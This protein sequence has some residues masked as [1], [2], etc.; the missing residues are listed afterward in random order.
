M[1]A[2]DELQRLEREI[3]AAERQPRQPPGK[4]EQWRPAEKPAQPER[5]RSRS[6]AIALAAC[7]LLVTTSVGID[8]VGRREPQSATAL[9]N[10]LTGA[11]A[12]YAMGRLRR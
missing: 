7:A 11:A 4:E 2:A 3:D 5:R 10:G 1:S 12:G 6:F 8:S 9:Q